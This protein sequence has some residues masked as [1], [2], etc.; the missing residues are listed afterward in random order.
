MVALWQVVIGE[1]VRNMEIQSPLSALAQA[2]K[3]L[4]KFDIESAAL[5]DHKPV[6]RIQV[7]DSE[8]ARV[9]DLRSTLV[10]ELKPTGFRFIALDL[11]TNSGIFSA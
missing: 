2:E 4:E 11:D 5:Y 6:L 9:L 8:F 7:S 1:N 3:I 10:E